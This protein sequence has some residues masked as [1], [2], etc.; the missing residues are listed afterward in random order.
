M[1]SLDTLATS[2][3]RYRA[4]LAK[5]EALLPGAAG[6]HR[7]MIDRLLK[8]NRAGLSAMQRLAEPLR[9]DG[10]ARLSDTLHPPR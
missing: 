5:L 10:F 8:G 3:D 1:I 7:S 4:D 9:T 6:Q 2:I